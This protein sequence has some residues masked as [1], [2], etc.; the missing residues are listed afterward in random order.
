MQTAKVWKIY[1]QISEDIKLQLLHNR[2]LGTKAEVD[3]FLNPSFKEFE[4]DLKIPGIEKAI[5]RINKAIEKKEQIIVYGDYDVDGITASAILYHGLTS[6]GAKVLPYIPHRE[7]EGYGLAKQGLE[8]ARDSGAALVITVDNGIVALEQA[9]FAKEIG[10][11]LIITDHH[12]PLEEKPEAVAIVHSTKM[13]GAAVA[14]CLIRSEISE[15]MSKELL[16]FVA[17]ATIC[18][19]ISLLGVNRA[20]VKEGLEKLNKTTNLGLL[21]LLNES[22][23][24][25]GN[26]GSYEIGHV[27]GP[28]I[29]AIGRLEHAIDAL[30]LLCT[31]DPDKAKTLARLCCDTNLKRQQLTTI[32]IDQARLL[33]DTDKKIHI[34]DSKEWIPGIIGLVASRISDEFYKP[35]I[36]ISVGEVYSK[37]SARSVGGLNIVETIRKS[38]D[39]LVDV[40]GHAG[41][42]GFTIETIKIKEFKKKIEELV[43]D[44]VISA[45]Q[46][47]EI[48]AEVASKKLKMS[49]VKELAEFEPFGLDNPRPLLVTRN[50]QVSDIRTV[51]EGKHLKFKADG[52]DAIAFSMGNLMNVLGNGKFVDIAYYLEIDRY[53]G[54]EKLQLKV[55]DLQITS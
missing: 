42:A 7:K 50:M 32:A 53:N 11:D 12:V 17:V 52:I 24:S 55:Q 22:G 19:M 31:R 26:I 4:N 18:D 20:F 16:Q 21:A 44:D 34:V 40:G 10:L 48:E 8:F 1:P 43:V 36:A 35:A 6:I 9:K 54:N 15:N 28:R 13:C 25:L 3:N 33:V 14:W 49:L 51:G 41:A 38:S 2:G 45:Q 46:V 27:L 39:I 30:R 29:N 37:G 47:L 23:L 5:K